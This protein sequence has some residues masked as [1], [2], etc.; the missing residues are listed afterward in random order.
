MRLDVKLDKARYFLGQAFCLMAPFFLFTSTV[1]AA[2]PDEE[3]FPEIFCYA[4]DSENKFV[5]ENNNYNH[6]L[7]EDLNTIF[8]RG[9]LRVLLQKKND[10]CIISKTEKLLIEEFA[11]THN[12]KIDWLYV[13]NDWELV[14]E[15]ITGNGD[16]IAGKN[17]SLVSGLHNK[18][19]FTHAWTSASYKV[20]QRSDTSRINRVQDLTGRHVAAYKT[21]P[22]WSYLVELSKTQTGMILQEIPKFDSYKKALERVKTG[23]YDLAVIDSLF[24]DQYLT[25]NNELQ[26]SLS[27]SDERNMAWAVRSDA[28]KLHKALNQYLNQQYLTHNVAS[29]YIDDLPAIK[30][31]GYLRVI[32]N[33]NLE[34]YYLNNGNLNG[35]EY[36]LLREF[37]ANNQIR[38]DVVIAKSKEEMF[39]LLQE[40]KGDVIAASLATNFLEHNDSFQYT[41]PYDYASPVVIGRK[42]DN[43]I[44]D[45]RDLVGKRISLSRNNPYWNYVSQLKEQGLDFELIDAAT[46]DVTTIMSQ[47]AFGIYDLTITGSHQIRFSHMKEMGLDTKFVL[48]EPLAHRW[49]VRTDSNQLHNALNEFIEREYRGMKYNLLHARYF[50]QSEKQDSLENR[51]V[52]IDSLSPY[53]DVTKYYSTKYGFD[54]RLITALMFQESRFNP[55]ANSYA[56]AKGVMQLTRTTAELMGLSDVKNVEKSIDAGVRYLS[57]LRDKFDNS[58]LLHDRMWFAV[59]S[60]NS[61]YTRLKRARL[62]A[63]KMGLDKNKWFQNVELAMLSMAKPYKKNGKKVRNCRCGQT[64]VYVREIRTRYFNYI[65]L[66]ETQQLVMRPYTNNSSRHRVN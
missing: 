19:S 33:A 54:W 3:F 18:I 61:G 25:A 52:K 15:L 62:L 16:V 57:H 35:F 13:N 12:L 66:T 53:D 22:I 11:N 40:G 41:K 8:E 64:V 51:L 38:V 47:V 39:K 10:D 5:T 55:N 21:S 34:H 48:F 9:T 31:R 46:E 63:E 4:S 20:V 65:R 2:N 7:S 28:K 43:L 45:V 42:K 26:T 49:A 44:V 14:T 59:A 56:G 60:Y 58:I 37:A 30:S 32:T 27:I 50:E 6:Q 36:E 1:L 29:I 24:I 17:Q 23:Q